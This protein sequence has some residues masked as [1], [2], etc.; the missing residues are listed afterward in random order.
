MCC[1]K[2]VELPSRPCLVDA[3]PSGADLVGTHKEEWQLKKK[4][5]KKKK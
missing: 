3:G 4:K 1:A 5:K 2:L